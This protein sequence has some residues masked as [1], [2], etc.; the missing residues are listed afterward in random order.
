MVLAAAICALVSASVSVVLTPSV[1]K[2]DAE[3][4]PALGHYRNITG[5][6]W[7]EAMH[8]AEDDY[9]AF[10]GHWRSYHTP[11][12]IPMNPD[13][14]LGRD[15]VAAAAEGK[16]LHISWRPWEPGGSWAESYDDATIDTV[17]TRL[18]D[19]CGADCWLSV[20]H[21]ADILATKGGPG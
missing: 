1:S 15:E 7:S 20:S 13:E 6:T 8:A 14:Q 9:G 5:H 11:G 10:D 12:S 18:R 21:E 2:A 17:M 4:R 16:R 3:A 19:Q